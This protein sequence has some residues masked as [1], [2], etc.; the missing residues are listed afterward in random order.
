MKM[1]SDT[2]SIPVISTRNKNEP[3][4]SFFIYYVHKDYNDTI[5]IVYVTIRYFILII[6]FVTFVT[7]DNSIRKRKGINLC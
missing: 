4:G 2:G 6:P 3:Y 7:S 1:L 5:R